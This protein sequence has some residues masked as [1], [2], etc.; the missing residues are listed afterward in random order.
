MIG[1]LFAVVS[2]DV[3]GALQR[4]WKNEEWESGHSSPMMQD[5]QGV[6]SKFVLEIKGCCLVEDMKRDND[7][8]QVHEKFGELLGLYV[9]PPTPPTPT[10]TPPTPTPPP[11][12]PTPPELVDLINSL[13]GLSSEEES[14]ESDDKK[15]PDDEEQIDDATASRRRHCNNYVQYVTDKRQLLNEFHNTV[16]WKCFKD[17]SFQRCLDSARSIILQKNK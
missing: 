7:Y 9:P 3:S 15:K 11:P 6:W 2:E 4:E 14:E 5:H 8:A 17:H 12:T 1:L 13:F 16:Q 10:P